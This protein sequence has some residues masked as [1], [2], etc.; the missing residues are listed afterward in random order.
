ML[1]EAKN[2]VI[3]EGILSEVDLS[4]GSFVKNGAAVENISGTIKIRVHAKDGAILEIPISMYSNKLKKDGGINPSYTSIENI[5]TQFKSIGATG[6]EATADAVRIS[7]AKLTMNEYYGQNGQLISYPRIRASFCSRIKKEEM[8]ERAEFDIEFVVGKMGNVVD[9]DGNDTDVYE[10]QG[11]VPQFGGKVDVIP[12]HTSTP[13]VT[14]VVSQSWA[15][16]DSVYAVG[17]LNF[18]SRVEETKVELGFGEPQIQ[19]HTINVSELLI[20]GGND[21]PL[22]ESIA[23]QAADISAALADRKNHLE[24]IKNNGARS[25][26]RQAPAPAAAVSNPGFDLGF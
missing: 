13:A 1:R 5:K 9:K 20:T 8:K 24:E 6:D 21:T 10:I 25:A 16:G 15:E 4:T 7:G 22:D 11:I 23:F 26:Q 17:R 14:N 12:F 3:I 2:N 19:T 18:T